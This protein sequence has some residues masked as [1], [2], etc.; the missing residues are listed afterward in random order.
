MHFG[1]PGDAMIRP[2]DMPTPQHRF[3]VVNDPPPLRRALIQY[4]QI[5]LD[6]VKDWGLAW[7]D[8]QP[9]KIPPASSR[10]ATWRPFTRV[11]RL[12]GFSLTVQPAFSSRTVPH[13]VT[14]SFDRVFFTWE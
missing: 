14:V 8:T 6:T 7:Q 12:I 13:D 2:G 9:V 10:K 5:S 3:L 11:T 4:G 1:K